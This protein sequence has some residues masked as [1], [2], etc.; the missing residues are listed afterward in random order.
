MSARWI[1]VLW[2]SVAVLAAAGVIA[3]LAVWQAGGFVSDKVSPGE[4]TDSDIGA[5]VTAPL[6]LK[7]VSVP[8]FHEMVGTIRSRDE[9]DISPRIT[10][11]V[12]NISKRSGDAVKKDEVL[13]QLDDTDLK[14]SYEAARQALGA[15]KSA[16]DT[17]KS[18]EIGA[19]A[20]YEVAE[21]E[22]KRMKRLLASGTI[23]K[24]RYDKAEGE[25]LTAK[26]TLDQTAFGIQISSAE[27]RRAA[28]NL[29]AAK[30]TLDYTVLRAPLAG[31]VNDRLADP[32]DMATVGNPVLKVFDP[33]R[34]MLQ[35]GVR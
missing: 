33:A 12:V 26:A 28:E 32:G 29:N 8:R 5:A 25:Y 27:V 17:A 30:A 2:R 16:L 20:A 31:I 13:V 4:S 3:V 14:A 15:A 23:A 11:R 34:L 7:T 6:E 35:A 22:Y 24:S 19:R 10:A 9:V 18:R 21:K 1:R